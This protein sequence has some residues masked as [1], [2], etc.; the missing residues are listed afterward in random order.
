MSISQT[1]KLRHKQAKPC[2]QG[3]QLVNGT[4][5]ILQREKVI[6]EARWSVACL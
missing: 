6:Y 3:H 5:K 4:S 2:V 1:R